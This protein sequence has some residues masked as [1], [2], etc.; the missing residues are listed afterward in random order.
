M[1]PRRDLNN[2]KKKGKINKLITLQFKLTGRRMDSRKGFTLIE[3]LIVITMISIIITV[4]APSF[5][6]FIQEGRVKSAAR[7]VAVGIQTARLRAINA[8]RRCYLDF[9]AGSLAPAD[10]FFTIWLDTNGNQSY[11]T[12]EI[13]SAQLA[14]PDTKSSLNGFKLPRGVTFAAS[15]LSYGPDSATVTADGVDFSG[16]DYVGFNSRG[17][18]TSSGAVYLTGE[19]GSIYAVSVS[20]LGAVRTFRWEDSQWK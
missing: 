13:D 12:G 3:L 5:S 15:G 1:I 18:S 20:G 6:G 2:R 17:E 8:N 19:N 7:S 11:D 14:M 16:N 4:G 10:S 9:S